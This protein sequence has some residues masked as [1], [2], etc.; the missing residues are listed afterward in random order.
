MVAARE[1]A[2]DPVWLKL[3][4]RFMAAPLA[5]VKAAALS[6]I[7]GP[8]PVVVTGASKIKAAPARLIPLNWVVFR[9]P[10]KLVVPVP[11]L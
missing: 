1:T 7:K 9:A 11:P 3:P 5:R 2:P 4:P 8:P 10:L 6:M